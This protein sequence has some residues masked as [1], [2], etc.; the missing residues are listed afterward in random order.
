MAYWSYHFFFLQYIRVFMKFINKSNVS[1]H[2]PSWGLMNLMTTLFWCQIRWWSDSVTSVFCMLHISFSKSGSHLKLS[3][4]ELHYSDS[5]CCSFSSWRCSTLL[6]CRASCL[7]PSISPHFLQSFSLSFLSLEMFLNRLLLQLMFGLPHAF[8]SWNHLYMSL[9]VLISVLVTGNVE[10][11]LAEVQKSVWQSLKF[12]SSFTQ[13]S[14][15]DHLLLGSLVLCFPSVLKKY[16][17]VFN[18]FGLQKPN[19]SCFHNPCFF[20]NSQ[21]L[22]TDKLL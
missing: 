11:C 16:S 19:L 7:S 5:C 8:A 21:I 2:W 1:V 15:S 13:S 14:R 3:A 12:S 10:S 22:F 18:F 6:L 17:V 9:Q 4:S 20:C